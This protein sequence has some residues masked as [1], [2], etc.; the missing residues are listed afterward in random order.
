MARKRSPAP[1]G[2]TG[3]KKALR[4]GEPHPPHPCFVVAIG[5]SAG[6]QE[7]LEQLFTVMPSDCGL[8]FLVVMHIPPT[9]PSFLAE[10]LERYTSMKTVTAEDEMSLLPN[11]V[12]VIPAGRDMVLEGGLLRLR[13]PDGTHH[14][15][16]RLFQS[17]AADP[18]F[19]KVAVV[20]S[21]SG[22]DGAT[23]ARAIR[24]AGGTVLVQ[25]PKTALYSGMPGSIIDAGTADLILP[26]AEIP[27][28]IAEIA[29]GTC[30]L[31]PPTCQPASIDEEFAT[32]CGIVKQKTGHDYSSYK[33]GTVLRRIERR[34]A[35]HEIGG[36]GKYIALLHES[37]QE[38]HALGQDIL[39]GVTS[40]FRDPEAFAVLRR[41]V[42]PQLFDGHEA[43]DPVRVWHACCATGEEVY[44]MAILM[45]EF[46]EEQRPDARVQLFATDIDETSIAQARAGLY[47]AD[48]EGEVGEKHLRKYFAMTDGRHYQV[49]K[50][51][52][53][54]VIFAHH[55][56]VKDPPFSR[57]DL[58]VCR[59]FLIYLNTDMQ[60]R[61]MSLFHQ[62]L[63]P[64]GFLFL[65]AS[66]TV[67]RHSDL[68]AT[69]DKKWRIYQRQE[70]G[71]RTDV[72]FP[73][74]AMVPRLPSAVRPTRP[75]GAVLPAPGSFAERFLVE[76]YAPS[77]VV[78]NEQYEVV[79]F[80]TRTSRFLAPP[81]GE[82]T[83]DIIRMAR[84][85]LRPSLRAAIHKA[86]TDQKQV[87]FRGV[88]LSGEG[89]EGTV[90][91][92]VEP[93]GA[94]PH[95]GRLATIV[96]ETAPAAAAPLPMSAGEDGSTASESSQ[97]TLVRLLEENLRIAQEQL[98]ATIE[99]LESSN[100]GFMSTNEE[101]ITIN[102]EYQATNEELQATNE[103]LETSKEELQALNEELSTVNVE[104]KGVVEEVK[105]A[106]T[107]LENLFASSE[108]ATIFLDRR[109][110]IK[111]FSA[112]MASIFNLI[113]A[114]IGRPFRHLAGK[115]DWPTFTLDA[116]T[117][118]AGQPFAEDEITTL[119]RERCYLKRIL[120]YRDQ[121][122]RID[123]LVVTFIDISERK[124]MEERTRH[125]ASFPRLNPNPVMELD[126]AGKVIYVNP[127]IGKILEDLGMGRTDTTAILPRDLNDI[128]R[129]WDRRSE[130]MLSREVT[131][132]ER[133][134]SM[135][136]HLVPQFGVARIYAYDSTSRKQAEEALRE[137]EERLRLFI[138]HA[139]AALA[140][141]DTDMRYLS[142][143]RRWLSD[144][145]LGERDLI[146]VSHYDV[147]P[148]I[149]AE[150]REVHRRGLAGEVLR[151]DADRF[152]RAD[153]SVQWLRWEIRPWF[154]AAGQ[155]GGIVIFAEDIT[156]MKQS[157]SAL[158]R[159][160]E[161]WERTFDSVPDLI[162]IMDDKHRIVRANRAMAERLGV[163]SQE[164][165][166][167]TC[168]LAVHDADCPPGV[169]P[170]AMTLTDGR[171]HQAEIH[172]ERL[173]GD[174]LI[175]TTPLLDEHGAM[176]GTVHVARD[177]T[178]RKRAEDMMRSRLRLSE[179]ARRGEIEELVK[180]AL[181]DAEHFTDSSIGF[182]HFVNDDQ[183]TLTLQAWSTNT[184]GNMCQAEG[185]GKHYPI[186]QAGG[187]VDCFRG[188][189]PVIH[190][191]YAGLTHRNGLPEGYAPVIREATIPVIRGDSVV[192]I[193]GVG[194]KATDYTQAD[195]DV[196]SEFASL[197]MDL[198]ASKRADEALRR[199]HDELELR[200][201][202]RTEE[203]ASAI[204]VLQEEIVLR[205]KAEESI[206]R[207]NRLYAVL[208]ETNQAIVR[209]SDRDSLFHDF[210]RI[211]VELG[212]FIL[213]WVGLVNGDNGQVR[214]IAASGATGYLDEVR[215]T[216]SEE[217]LGDGPT[218]IA[219]REGT[220]CICND[221]QNDPRTR[222]WHGQG[223]A[224]GIRA[225]ASIALKQGGRV[226]GALTLYADTRDFFDPQQEK[227]LL[228]MGAD[229]SFALDNLDREARRREAEAALQKETLE[230]LQTLELL[231]T[232][233]QML[234]QQSRLAAMGEMI[235]NI[236]HQWRQPLNALGLTIQQLEV[237]YECG[238]FSKEQFDASVAQAMEII[239]HMSQTIEDFRNFYR[240]DK[241]KSWFDLGQLLRKTVSLVEANFREDQ[242]TVEIADSDDLEITGYPN[243]YA[244]VILN[245]LMNARDAFNE[246]QP[247]KRRI[248]IRYG[249][250]DGKTVVT[251]TDN[252]GGI[253][254][255][256]ME[257][258]FD[259]YF[260]TKDQGLGTG[261]GLFMSKTIIEKN[262]G[263]RL[264]AANVD[265][266]A[267]FR[268]EV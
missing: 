255:E 37:P 214:K 239:Y 13:V 23:G 60:K 172:E 42:I 133:V 198:V 6:G 208:S 108:I 43:E 226:V 263:G 174:F 234:I 132:K 233:E 58:I 109:L 92:Q 56:L 111:R 156:D 40:F 166:G 51:L 241:E 252:A 94:P 210:C 75:T 47:P 228:Q 122:G 98:Q 216:A 141:F 231:R 17:L 245:I 135:S 267:E 69:V 2:G 112:A 15:V 67:G 197:V 164:C 27:L 250:E 189:V 12:Q 106:N 73:F 184:L 28:K 48:I 254:E 225:S 209:A 213:S 143:S 62:V 173:G 200:V 116:E 95:A 244:Q 33:P 16:D 139:P 186:D 82:P 84:E 123:G 251:V 52:R 140:M 264:T 240:P 83:L 102:E 114:D 180:A 130:A 71:R 21:G 167:E 5:A 249:R 191:D 100:E 202:E 74:A 128:L 154:S 1:E 127:A 131:V 221:F 7:A 162:A 257:K 25:D 26:P 204:N 79:Y 86:F 117:V 105:Q 32:I 104:L 195:V 163:A 18:A 150:W 175:T 138:E 41:K 171:E 196:L 248:H 177:I 265:G 119:D 149:S 181:D 50:Q 87:V 151:A 30:S 146:G 11:R 220:Y 57:L 242:I 63:K 168:Y 38:A 96:F 193:M 64:G 9:G 129:E 262:M 194:N 192:A 4:N 145:G 36:L 99:Q 179:L 206:R 211:A 76:R 229:I 155:V 85:E 207:I 256:I 81:V 72:P 44:S 134:Y 39:I 215:I 236:A 137:N 246:R 218:G 78:V 169:C 158:K 88:K 259:P 260:T 136:V 159:A 268:I 261:V 247:D 190:N 120:P 35:V 70:S 91:I 90:T 66:E 148:E 65:G 199:A 238:G 266:G 59:N 147:F 144:Y 46:M 55:S 54:M 89:D 107:D 77:C 217:P 222:P 115:I 161:E 125:I 126:A 230:R 176:M 183:E 10:M 170:H 34:M 157:E 97:D 45:R 258:I 20:L 188:R 93:I 142:V 8:S 201:A 31:L 219:I 14:P 232:K 68:F 80:S 124:Q 237:S 205:E 24:D 19:R 103:E 49:A 243:E 235:G 53:E 187:W 223:K 29:R 224:Y 160:K 152:E 185:K 203:L 101:L 3:P 61:L 227:L 113:P 178:E 182:F 118:M 253:A 153:G 121:E 165:V 212:G 110:T 22:S